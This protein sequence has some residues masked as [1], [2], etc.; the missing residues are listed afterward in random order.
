MLSTESSLNIK[1]RIL[2]FMDR[3][4]QI[5]CD[6]LILCYLIQFYPISTELVRNWTTTHRL[7]FSVHKIRQHEN[8]KYVE[9]VD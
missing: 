3:K 9:I 4:L 7:Q 6:T 5:V 8:R 1:P 2:S